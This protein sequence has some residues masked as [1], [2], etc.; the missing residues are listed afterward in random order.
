[1][2]LKHWTA[3]LS[4]QELRVM[5]STLSS[6]T[7]TLYVAVW[8]DSLHTNGAPKCRI[9]DHAAHLECHN[10]HFKHSPIVKGLALIY[11]RYLSPKESAKGGL[12][13]TKE[14]LLSGLGAGLRMKNT[15]HEP[16]VF[17]AF[18]WL[19][20]GT[21]VWQRSAWPWVI[22]GSSRFAQLSFHCTAFLCPLMNEK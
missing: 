15:N 18:K 5:I 8:G 16:I 4:L 12:E 20:S 7:V 1:M 13:Q 9:G 11:K 2:N 21:R 14:N 19:E 6:Q 17:H 3:F 22:W 10:A